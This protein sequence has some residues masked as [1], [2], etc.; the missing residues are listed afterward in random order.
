MGRA[1]YY[2]K[3]RAK[4]KAEKAYVQ[5]KIKSDPKMVEVDKWTGAQMA[6]D[7]L[8][9]T[10]GTFCSYG[11]D[12]FIYVS[13]ERGRVTIAGNNALVAWNRAIGLT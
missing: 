3:Y 5:V 9:E 7:G 8:I 11:P 2:R 6:L 10:E 1:E 4:R 13:P 12:G